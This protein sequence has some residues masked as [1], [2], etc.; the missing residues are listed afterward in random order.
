M[1]FLYRNYP[2]S[3]AI[4]DVRYE[5]S[6]G[7]SENRHVADLEFGDN[8]IKEWVFRYGALRW[9]NPFAL[10]GFLKIRMAFYAVSK[11]GESA[12]LEACKNHYK[13]Q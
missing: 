12:W 5:Y 13:N 10:I 1:S 11:F 9:I 6:D 4:H 2:V 7:F 3:V 8:L